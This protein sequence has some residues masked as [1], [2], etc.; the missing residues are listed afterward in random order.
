MTLRSLAAAWDDFWFKPQPPT[1]IALYRILFGVLVLCYGALLASDLLVWLGPRG[2]LSQA[3][4]YQWSQRAPIH[5]IDGLPPG[6]GWVVTFFALFMWAALCLTLGISTRLSG[7]L[8]F[9]GLVSIHHR[10]MLILNSGD[11]LL[12]INAFLLIFS[13]AGTALSLDRLRRVRSG[14]ET[15]DPPQSA[16]W[17]QRLI[18]VQLAMMY[19]STFLVKTHG[20]FW[21]NGTAVYYVT[22]LQEFWRFPVPYLFEHLWMIRCLTWGTLLV[23]FSLAFL[24]WFSELRYAVLAAGLLLHLGLEYSMNVPLFQWIAVS[25]YVTFLEPQ[26]LLR[27]RDWLLRKSFVFRQAFVGK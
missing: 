15:G 24:V 2:I 6:D 22:R 26:H 21:L 18:Q 20:S 12:R 25:T 4:A 13:P 9:L 14:L 8:V 23:E 11:T 27:A 5:L 1:A 16:P 17:A 3:T 10:N 19:F 7:L